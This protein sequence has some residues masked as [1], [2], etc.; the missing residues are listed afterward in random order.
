MLRKKHILLGVTGGIAAYKIPLLVREFKKA[1]ADVRIVMTEAA[2][3]FVTPLTLS[4][5]SGEDVLIGTFPKE[6][7][8]VLKGK[9]WHIH[10]AEWADVLLIAPATANLIAKLAHGISDDAV[11]T[12]SLA[13]HKS[14]VVS[15]AMDAD[16]WKHTATERN[17][18]TLRETGYT[19]LPPDEG[20]LASGLIGPGRLPELNVII[21]AVDV[22]LEKSNQDLRG[23]N[24]VVTA[25]PT[26][27]AIDPVRY[28]CNRSSGKMGFAIANVAAQRGAKVTLISGPVTLPTPRNV[29]RVDVE[30]AEDMYRATMK[31]RN[32]ADVIIMSAAVADFT[33]EK[34][35]ATKIKKGG[36]NDSVPS[37]ELRKTKDIL[38]E[39]TKTKNKTIVVGFA[40]ET[41]HALAN[42]KKKLKEKRADFIVLNNATEEGAGFN[43]ETNIITILSKRGKVERLKKMLKFDTAH[44]ILNRVVKIL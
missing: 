2:K 31:Y 20:E 44:E 38:S 11:T 9:T 17:V 43:T 8:G 23:K 27:E 29:Q 39:L 26:R 33:P 30:S 15:P 28:I 10:L 4:T 7:G 16:M 3:E 14:V 32:K 19:V 37:I 42:A 13:F 34:P 24:I 18:T 6:S 12:L 40:L 25:G 41:D 21:E 36:K 35:S 22:V 5:L 1:G